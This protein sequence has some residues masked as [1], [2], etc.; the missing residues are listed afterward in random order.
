MKILLMAPQPFF[1]H[2]GTPIAVRLLAEVLG[3]NGHE[4]HLLVFHEGEDVVM[5]NVTVHR[6]AAMPG[7]N[8][9]PPGFSVKKLACDLLFWWKSMGLHMKNSFDC[10][11]A[12]EESVFIAMVNRIFF[13]VPYVY[14]L[15]S[16]LSDQLVTKL[17]W[18]RPLRPCFE[19]FEKRA[20]RSSIGVVAVCQALADMA[21]RLAP[22][23]P[24]LLLEDIS[25]IEKCSGNGGENLRE[26]LSINARI[27]LYVGNLESY[28]GIDLLL[29][30]FSA[31]RSDLRET[32]NLVIIGGSAD[33]IEK[34]KHRSAEL[35]IA[36][37]VFFLGPRPITDLGA[38]L[39][40]ADILVS[41][42]TEGENTPM[43][44]YSYMDSGKVIVATKIR[45]HTQVLDS[46]LAV[47]VQPEPSG[48]AEGLS[49]VLDNYEE[50]KI[51]A[52]NAGIVVAENYSRDAFEQ[53]LTGF[54]R[55]LS[56][57]IVTTSKKGQ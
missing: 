9:V 11:H 1:Q 51:L 43:K 25:L 32:A 14:D 33:H 54:Y 8:E 40:Q 49:F 29:E 44:I 53:K 20:L 46:S 38:Y 21:S 3:E 48:F 41:P 36:D 56:Q 22:D 52:G 5:E 34:Y 16:C 39:K 47:L 26:M 55:L 28:Q 35:Q 6:I 10:V 24:L 15:D 30:G 37:A 23:K 12:V 7:L 17:R 19:W 27:I 2:R 45:S 4:V 42:R 57:D 18:L 13:R 31:L 50:A